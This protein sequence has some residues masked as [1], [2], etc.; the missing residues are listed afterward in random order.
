MTWHVTTDTKTTK[1][2][3]Y[4]IE[5][6]F[7]RSKQV[8]FKHTEVWQRDAAFHSLLR[9]QELQS[10]PEMFHFKG[11]RAVSYDD[12]LGNEIPSGPHQIMS[13]LV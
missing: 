7:D 13:I 4:T 6:A 10:E 9:E 1:G 2:C 11:T 12:G 8:A 5:I 3:W